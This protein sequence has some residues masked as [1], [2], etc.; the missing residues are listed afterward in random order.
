MD[1]E[2]SPGG[3]ARGALQGRPRSGAKP[4]GAGPTD[5]NWLQRHYIKKNWHCS[6]MY[7]YTYAHACV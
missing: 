5:P 1:G 6:R 2:A 7:M 3:P 4:S